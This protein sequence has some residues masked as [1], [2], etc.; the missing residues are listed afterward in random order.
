[1][2]DYLNLWLFMFDVIF[3]FSFLLLLL[4]FLIILLV[5]EA[6]LLADSG[7]IAVGVR[8]EVCGIK[9]ILELL[10]QGSKFFGSGPGSRKIDLRIVC[11]IL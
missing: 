9:L 8:Y 3:F 1:M 11:Y 7:V 6:V 2:F 5:S 10:S 4:G